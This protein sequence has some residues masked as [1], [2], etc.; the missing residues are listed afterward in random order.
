MKC[1]T[2]G[3]IR[4]VSW[5]FPRNK[6]AAQRNE[7]IVEAHEESGEEVEVNN[8]PEEGESLMLKRVLVNT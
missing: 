4:H 5:E 3:E 7:N 8:P 6:P 1:Y 2:C